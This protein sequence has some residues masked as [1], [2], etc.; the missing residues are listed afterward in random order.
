MKNKLALIAL[1]NATS[2]SM[3][4]TDSNANHAIK[5]LFYSNSNTIQFLVVVKSTL[6][7]AATDFKLFYFFICEILAGNIYTSETSC[8]FMELTFMELNHLHQ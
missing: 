2:L 3:F 7:L 6:Y 1:V 8:A 4:R 5:M